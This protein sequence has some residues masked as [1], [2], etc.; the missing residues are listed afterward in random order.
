MKF[1]RIV[2]LIVYLL[3]SVTANAQKT[4]WIT[5]K[6]QLKNFNNQVE[7]ADMSEFQYL[8]PPTNTRMIVPDSAGNFSIRFK[9]SEP[10]YYRIGRNQLY[11]SPGDELTVF[12][13]YNDPTKGRFQGIGESANNYLKYTPFPKGGS[14]LEAGKN[15]KNTPEETVIEVERLAHERFLAL[16]ITR[17]VSAEFRRLETARLKADIINSLK[18]GEFYSVYKLKLKDTAAKSYAA[19]YVKSVAPKVTSHSENF[20]DAS[21]MKLVV[22]RDIA[23]DELIKGKGNDAAIQQIS[24]WYKATELVG[25]MQKLSDKKQLATFKT[26]IGAI[27]T[28]AYKNAVAKMLTYLLQFGKGDHAVD[29]TAINSKGEKINLSSLKG[30]VIYVDLWA[31]WCGPCMQ[32]M[33][34]FEKLK[35]KY[36]NNP[37]VV[38]VSLSIDDNNELWKASLTQRKAE[39]YQW[40]INRSKLQAYNIVGI[41]R[42][43]LIDKDFKMVDLAAPMPSQVAAEKAI[44]ALLASR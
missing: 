14:F 35:A 30:K 40:I 41:P 18:M 37:N 5:L 9:I 43:L 33:P 22:Y 21:L 28:T 24:D 10:N 32:E 29:F 42:S 16:A 3:I 36:A 6:G 11:L 17:N 1:N 27:K 38:F 2:G 12:I 26:E 8:L 20:I 4:S 19:F 13:D 31:T 25:K 7:I 15:V 34:H 39:G 23:D 44:D